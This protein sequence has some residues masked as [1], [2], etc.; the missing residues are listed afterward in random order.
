MTGQKSQRLDVSRPAL[1]LDGAAR[2]DLGVVR[3]LGLG[4]IPVHLLSHRR[5]AVQRSRF[6]STVHEF[7]PNAS[8]DEIRVARLRAIA[9]GLSQRPVVFATGDSAV[10]FLSRTR[11]QWSDLI[12]HDLPPDDVVATCVDKAT[13]AVAAE[14]LGLPVPETVVPVDAA[15]VARRAPGLPYPLFVKPVAREAWAGLPPGT[16]RQIRGQRVESAAELVELCRRLEATGGLNIIIQKFV[17]SPDTEHLSVHAYIDRDRRVVGT[18]SGSKLRVFPPTAGLGAFVSSKRSLAAIE[19]AIE[20]LGKL[21]YT[22]FAILNLKRD[23]ERNEYRLLEINCRHSTWAELPTRCGCNF[24]V[25]AYA[26]M[27]GQEPPTLLQV[28]G[29][30]WLDFSRDFRA[31]RTYR[32]TTE[33]TWG[34]YIRSLATVRCWAFFALDDPGPFLFE[35]FHGGT[36]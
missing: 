28:E 5:S 19:I 8:D 32:Q 31:L 22:G 20:V 12:D 26:A 7:P 29:P 4:G 21:G 10:R 16:V 17:A 9:A 25:A 36:A 35:T 3:S 2:G 33:W 6:V 14:R 11:D 23:A 30:S 15:D 27:T 24:P 1:V 34:S 18:F 13:F